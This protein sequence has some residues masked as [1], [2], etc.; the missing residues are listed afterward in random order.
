M[1]FTIN[2]YYYSIRLKLEIKENAFI[3]NWTRASPKSHE[4]VFGKIILLKY[5]KL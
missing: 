1:Q 5:Q 4:N 2:C 3:C